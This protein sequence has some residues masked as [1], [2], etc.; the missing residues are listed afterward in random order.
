MLSQGTFHSESFIQGKIE[1]SQMQVFFLSLPI[2]TWRESFVILIIGRIC[3][4]G[5]LVAFKIWWWIYFHMF[6]AGV[7]LCCI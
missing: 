5:E 1:R 7:L 3:W 4:A 2:S 6:W